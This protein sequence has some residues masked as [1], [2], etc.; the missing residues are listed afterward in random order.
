M[1][2]HTKRLFEILFFTCLLPAAC[3]AFDLKELG[4]VLEKTDLQNVLKTGTGIDMDSVTDYLS[5]DDI[6]LSFQGDMT[7]ITDTLERQVHID[8]KVYKRG[9][10]KV[11]I[12]AKTGLQILRAEKPVTLTD[13]YILRYPFKAYL[14]MPLKKGY[15]ELDPDKSRD[16][17]G[18]L[19]KKHKDKSATIDKKEQLGQEEIDGYL[20]E[21]VRVVMTL[22][23]G[24]KSNITAWLSEKLKG[25]PL[26][27]ISDHISPAGI[28]TKNTTLFSN[29]EEMMPAEELFEIPKDYTEYDTL[30]ELATEGKLGSRIKNIKKKK[31]RKKLFKRK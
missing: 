9:L 26:K 20:C 25:F 29:L 10:G 18:E 7:S 3:F 27:I 28:V 5:W 21:K 23:N 12:D 4:N 17:L 31:G 22:P 15:L 8:A 1:S 2:L 16:M 13:S 19:Q 30:L 24:T 14:V 6:N 11:R